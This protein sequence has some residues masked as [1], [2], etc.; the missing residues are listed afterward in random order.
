M[1]NGSK[2]RQLQW[3]SQMKN[4][5][6]STIVLCVL[7]CAR[8]HLARAEDA[9]KTA[10]GKDVAPTGAPERLLKIFSMQNIQA[11]EAV[12]IIR[13]VIATNS[14]PAAERPRFAV[15]PARNALIV[16]AD[17]KTLS[18][19]GALIERLDQRR[20]VVPLHTSAEIE[21][22]YIEPREAESALRN[23]GID[24]LRT[25]ANLR[26][27]TVILN[28]SK[29]P[30]E[31][32]RK[33]IATLDAPPPEKHG[34]SVSLRLVWLVDKSLLS[35][36]TPAVPSDL[37]PAIAALRKTMGIGE[38]R[39]ASQMLV[40][41]DPADLTPFNV[42][43]TASLKH[44]VHLELKGNIL[45]PNR[46]NLKFSGTEEPNGKEICSFN[47]TSGALVPGYPVIIGMTTLDSHPSVVVIELMPK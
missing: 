38:L 45:E 1:K 28:G 18:I 34:E 32:A 17:S 43:G 19:V 44:T 21:L 14:L 3:E 8:P 35:E 12:S 11:Q 15:D 39:T 6:L 10:Q 26:R 40:K 5:Y 20:V 22:R 36:D 33:L 16:S 27:K 46:L 9:P 29:E 47:T 23:L 2:N 37:D 30:V 13:E 42:S 41:V 25:V 4:G 31:R 7:A 24:G